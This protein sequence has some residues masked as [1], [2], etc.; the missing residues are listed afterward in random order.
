MNEVQFLPSSSK[1][2]LLAMPSV[3]LATLYL[4]KREALSDEEREALLAVLKDATNNGC[5]VYKVEDEKRSSLREQIATSRDIEYRRI[6][7][8]D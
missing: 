4:Q 3:E 8:N 2:E 1:I 5:F 6:K 7:I